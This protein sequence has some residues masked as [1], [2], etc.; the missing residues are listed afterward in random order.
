[1]KRLYESILDTDFDIEDK[2]LTKG[3]IQSVLDDS[4]YE[5]HFEGEFEIIG[6]SLCLEWDGRTMREFLFDEM[7]EGLKGLP[8]K[9]KSIKFGY[10]SKGL[11]DVLLHVNHNITYSSL[12][13][14]AGN[15]QVE[16]YAYSMSSIEVKF[17]NFSFLALR[18]VTFDHI[19]PVFV[20]KSNINTNLINITGAHIL[21]TGS[22]TIKTGLINYIHPTKKVLRVLKKMGAMPID[23]KVLKQTNPFNALIGCKL[24]GT[25]LRKIVIIIDEEKKDEYSAMAFTWNRHYPLALQHYGDKL[26][27]TEMADG[28]IYHYGL[29]HP[30]SETY[31]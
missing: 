3:A 6:D 19:S 17:K 2:N 21:A 8:I 11:K 9:I 16:G 27:Q 30:W 10:L 25:E 31:I 7:Y 22:T 14:W 23:E 4:V 1:M 18:T 12:T 26:G 24:E 20:G 28:W 15:I 5:E 29:Q 13:V